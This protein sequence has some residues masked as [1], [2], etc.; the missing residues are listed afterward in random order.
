MRKYIIYS[1]LLLIITIIIFIIFLSTYGFKT[2][3]FNNLIKGKINAL[4]PKL[5]LDIK[6]VYLKLNFK[7]KSININTQNAKLYFKKEFINLSKIDLNLDI[8]KFINK[9]NSLK[10]AKISTKNS[11][12][13]DIT[14][15]VNEYK[16]S[17]PR[18][19]IFNQIVL[20]PKSHYLFF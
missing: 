3:K 20:K 16:F 14:N 1:S 11:K 7:E 12:I 15:F 6:D 10:T 5:S 2:N 8:L 13:K 4:D 9:E 19:I 17:I 18:A